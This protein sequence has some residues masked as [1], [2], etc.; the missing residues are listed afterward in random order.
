VI[1]EATI[2]PVAGQVVMHTCDNPPCCNPAHLRI[3]TTADNVRDKWAKG[4]G[5]VNRTRGEDRPGAKLRESDVRDIRAL[6]GAVP[7]TEI[8]R[9]FG[10]GKSTV[11]AIATGDSWG[12]LA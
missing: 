6:L 12:W 1:A 9:R 10:V 3:G 7:Q 5:G 8:A 11:G 2:G 4:R